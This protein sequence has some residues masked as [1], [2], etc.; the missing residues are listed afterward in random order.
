MFV[1]R[2]GDD[3]K[4]ASKRRDAGDA[5]CREGLC[6]RGPG[7]NA[8]PPLYPPI[9]RA[10]GTPPYTYIYFIPVVSSVVKATLT[11]SSACHSGNASRYKMGGR[12]SCF[13]DESHGREIPV[14]RSAA[15]ETDGRSFGTRISERACGSS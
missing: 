2:T 11:T 8:P 13:G 4:K 3:L 7:V 1:S 6:S 12:Y 9:N 15:L 5:V 10:L 14:S